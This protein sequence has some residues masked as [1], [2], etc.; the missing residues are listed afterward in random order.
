MK[1]G[2]G[3]RIAVANRRWRVAGIAA[4]TVALLGPPGVLAQS[5]SGALA[6]SATVVAATRAEIVSQASVLV[7]TAD[8]VRRGYVDAPAASRLMV[9]STS[10]AGYRVHLHPRIG[11]FRAVDVRLGG[12]QARLGSD[13]GALTAIGRVGR[14]QTVDVDYRFELAAG[15][16]PGHYPWP[17]VLDARPL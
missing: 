16:A 11:L 8:D 3:R 13:G 7:V 15:V 14:H 1:P 17:L 10:R 2:S 6:V 5:R 12:L 9:T 4:C